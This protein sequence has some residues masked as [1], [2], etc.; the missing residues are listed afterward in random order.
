MLWRYAVVMRGDMVFGVVFLITDGARYGKSDHPTCNFYPL[1]LKRAFP[2]PHIISNLLAFMF[3]ALHIPAVCSLAA[4][5]PG[6]PLACCK[7]MESVLQWS[8][9][10]ST[11][12]QEVCCT[13]VSIPFSFISWRICI[14]RD[15][16]QCNRPMYMFNY[17][18]PHV[19]D[20]EWICRWEMMRG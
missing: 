6:S 17:R 5:P 2:T 8:N 10:C 16:F 15:F 9:K 7:G 12:G 20:H 18:F 3:C 14:F 1:V 19:A 11:R 4:S 13:L